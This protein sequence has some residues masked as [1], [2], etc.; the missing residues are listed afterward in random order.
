MALRNLSP[1]FREA[2]LFHG[3][4]PLEV[5][6]HPN[7]HLVSHGTAFTVLF[8][9]VLAA[10]SVQY[11]HLVASDREATAISLNCIRALIEVQ[12]SAICFGLYFEEQ[13]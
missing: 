3:L 1:G 8:I 9:G 4:I 6:K 12:L 13:F 5:N 10:S 2:L 7:Q 11:L